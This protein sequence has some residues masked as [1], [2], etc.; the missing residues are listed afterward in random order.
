[1]AEFKPPGASLR[2]D[3][4]LPRSN[5]GP[6]TG[7]F[8][9]AANRHGQV[10]FRSFLRIFGTNFCSSRDHFG[11]IFSRFGVGLVSCW[12][13]LGSVLGHF[14]VIL[15]PVWGHFGTILGSFCCLK[16]YM[17]RQAGIRR[18]GQVKRK[19]CRLAHRLRSARMCQHRFLLMLLSFFLPWVSDFL[20]TYDPGHLGFPAS[21]SLPVISADLGPKKT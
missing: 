20:K 4:A 15:G 8:D 19:N 3:M 9:L 10:I 1:M 21:Q 18:H 5:F 11:I 6:L 12:V 16:A 13:R 7:L 2:R 14:G 17:P